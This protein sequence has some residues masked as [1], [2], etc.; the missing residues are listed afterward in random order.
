M[1][2][3]RILAKDISIRHPK[4]FFRCLSLLDLPIKKLILTFP[5]ECRVSPSG[6]ALLELLKSEAQTRGI[7]LIAPAFSPLS[8]PHHDHNFSMDWFEAALKPGFLERF[9]ELNAKKISEDLSY[10]F[11]LLFSELTQNAKD[12]AGS[13]RYLVWLTPEEIGV[14]DLGVTIPAKLEQKYN[15]SNDLESIEA[16]LKRGTTTRRLRP[17]GLG[18]YYTLDLI[19][20]QE[21]YLYIASRHGQIRRYHANKK[22]D[23]KTLTPRMLGTLIYCKLT[24][25]KEKKS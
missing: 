19:K 7:Q 24:H 4:W 16:A 21:G 6:Q 12:H 18:L 13:E 22:I 8:F 9:L 20:R 25:E 17:G 11:Q 23:R 2:K 1:K 3:V 14:F 10:D 5:K 15:F